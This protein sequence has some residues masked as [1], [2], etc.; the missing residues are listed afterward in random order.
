MS[1]LNGRQRDTRRVEAGAELNR[2]DEGV[3]VLVLS[4]LSEF[5]HGVPQVTRLLLLY[6]HR[7]G[8]RCVLGCR[9]KMNFSKSRKL[10]LFFS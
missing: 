8:R 2:P 9:T 7:H 4:R 6:G 10:L 3:D 1:E 5:E